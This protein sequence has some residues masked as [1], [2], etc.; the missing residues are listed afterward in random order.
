MS[1]PDLQEYKILETDTANL[2]VR[3]LAG[4]PEAAA[5]VQKDVLVQQPHK[6]VETLGHINYFDAMDQLAD[7][8]AA[9]GDHAEAHKIMQASVKTMREHDILPE[10]VKAA[11]LKRNRLK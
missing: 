2:E 3:S 8:V 1:T 4:D 9:T 11:E 6:A 5:Q 7:S 10:V